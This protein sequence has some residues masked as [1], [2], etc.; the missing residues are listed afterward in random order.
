MLPARKQLVHC[1]LLLYLFVLL[2]QPASTEIGM[3]VAMKRTCQK[4]W[5]G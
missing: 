2:T 3:Q 5:I 1:Q 4:F